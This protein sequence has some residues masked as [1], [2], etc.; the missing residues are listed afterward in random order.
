[1]VGT[2]ITECIIANKDK[3]KFITDVWEGTCHYW[4]FK[5]Y[6]NK[7]NLFGFRKCIKIISYTDPKG[8]LF[9]YDKDKNFGFDIEIEF[10]SWWDIFSCYNY[11]EI[12]PGNQVM[13]NRK[14]SEI[15]YDAWY[16][17]TYNEENAR[18]Q[19]LGKVLAKNLKK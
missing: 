17:D 6:F 7:R 8:W 19:K 16:R 2:S 3:I 9:R 10:P 4:L 18:W 15:L 5:L 11:V 12:E 13:D 1:M 14:L